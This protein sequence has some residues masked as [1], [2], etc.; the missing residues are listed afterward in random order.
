VIAVGGS[1]Q[2][3]STWR[4][5][6]GQAVRLVLA[7][8]HPALADGLGVILDSEADFTVCGLAHDSR[9]AVQLAATHQPG[10][11]LLDPHLPNS[12]PIHVLAAIKAA[13]PTTRVLLLAPP[14]SRSSAVA[15]AMAAGADGMVTRSASSEQLAEAIRRV[16]DGRR[17]MVAAAPRRALGEVSMELLR[18]W[19]LSARELEIL[20]LLANGWSNRRIAQEWHLSL[21][22]VRTHVQN[23]LVKL[24][25]HSRLE[26]VAFA[27]QHG[28]TAGEVA[29]NRHSA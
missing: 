29:R 8:G 13:S 10:V 15:A 21:A 27:F 20:G 28:V 11:L 2:I 5:T 4:R 12:D 16:V 25:V 17:A 1:W 18:V 14:S 26:A 19:T 23:V 6:V 7:D 22:T 9:Q 24:G 3:G